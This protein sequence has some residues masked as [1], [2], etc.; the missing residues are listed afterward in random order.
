ME[1]NVYLK[2]DKLFMAFKMFDKDGNGK[3]SPQELKEAL[4]SKKYNLVLNY[5]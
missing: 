3:I 4:G 2:E 5:F 1:R